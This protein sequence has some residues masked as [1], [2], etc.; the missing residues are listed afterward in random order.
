MAIKKGYTLIEL[1]IVVGLVSILAIGI[2]SAVLINATTA[3]RT[4]NTTHLRNVGDYSLSQLKQIIRSSRTISLCDS[5][6]NTISLINQ[7]G[8]TTSISIEL[9]NDIN[10][11]ASNSGIYLTP[12]ETSIT[13]FTITC[14]PTD[15][16][17]TIVKISF[18]TQ[19][20]TI[21]TTKESPTIHFTTS[22][23]PRSN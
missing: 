7:D 12:K 14:L 5:N 20:A 21:S 3:I 23:T 1:V 17:P 18:D 6:T 15:I 16:N 22:I 2:S 19:L 9:D 11:I 10:R 8:D 4:K 13:N